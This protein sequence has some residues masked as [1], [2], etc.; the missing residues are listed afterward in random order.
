M[1]Q[2]V[3]ERMVRGF[4]TEDVGSGDVTTAA[5]VPAGTRARARITQKQDGVISGLDAAAA[6]FH[7]TDPDA[8]VTRLTDEGVSGMTRF[9]DKSVLARFGLPSTIALG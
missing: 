3:L 9:A 5:T 6:T 7:A 2:R 1:D 8:S 4:L